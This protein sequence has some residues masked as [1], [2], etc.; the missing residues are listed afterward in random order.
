MSV[1]SKQKANLVA[2]T[3]LGCGAGTEPPED[4][5]VQFQV[6]CS[7]TIRYCNDLRATVS[8]GA[9]AK[10]EHQETTSAAQTLCDDAR[11]STPPDA[12][13]A[14]DDELAECWVQCRESLERDCEC[15]VESAKV[16]EVAICTPSGDVNV[17][18]VAD[19]DEDKEPEEPTTCG[20]KAAKYKIVHARYEL[21][22]E[23]AGYGWTDS[24]TV[25]LANVVGIGVV[26][27]GVWYAT[28]SCADPADPAPL[29]RIHSLDATLTNDQALG[30]GGKEVSGSGFQSG[31]YH[32]ATN[33]TDTGWLVAGKSSD[34]VYSFKN[35]AFSL[36]KDTLF[37]DTAQTVREPVVRLVPG[38]GG[39]AIWYRGGVLLPD[40]TPVMF[41][42]WK[43]IN[44]VDGDVQSVTVF[45]GQTYA[46]FASDAP[47]STLARISDGAP[48][49]KVTTLG[50]YSDVAIGRV[51]ENGVS[52]VAHLLNADELRESS[53][54]FSVKSPGFAAT[55]LC[56]DEMPAELLSGVYVAGTTPSGL[57][58]V[59]RSSRDY[60]SQPGDKATYTWGVQGSVRQCTVHSTNTFQDV[61]CLVR[62]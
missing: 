40:K 48:A 3:L 6:N 55:T 36:L 43:Q 5:Y 59:A 17:T 53:G 29:T 26:G 37:S 39:L 42:S 12:Q 22:S 7:F 18:K 54:P 46:L 1:L 25:E 58:A 20:S 47:E 35:G 45:E 41:S 24:H 28:T 44:E 8:P 9:D 14:C 2:I 62:P 11:R 61:Y 16:G 60:V 57:A 32:F 4:P 50:K 33:G 27:D 30:G 23:D 49:L 52:L 15:E 19:P 13:A 51:A 38:G 56:T 21:I 34:A 10:C 31:N